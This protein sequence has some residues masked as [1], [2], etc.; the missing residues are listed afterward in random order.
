MV[1]TSLHGALLN[2]GFRRAILRSL[3]ARKG[4]GL[5]ETAAPDGDPFD[6]LADALEASLDVPALD[7]IVWGSP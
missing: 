2:R 1:G 4:V 3:A 5:P 7:R 6:R